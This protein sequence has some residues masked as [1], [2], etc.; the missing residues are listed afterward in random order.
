MTLRSSTMTAGKVF[1]DDLVVAFLKPW[2]KATCDQP[3]QE[4]GENVGA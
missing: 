2:V 3:R 1:Y 4:D